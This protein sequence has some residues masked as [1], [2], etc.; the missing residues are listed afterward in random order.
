MDGKKIWKMGREIHTML[1]G[2]LALWD[3]NGRAIWMKRLK[4]PTTGMDLFV[5][6]VVWFFG[7]LPTTMAVV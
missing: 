2:Q 7:C 5:Q 4:L 1:A 6:T 3:D